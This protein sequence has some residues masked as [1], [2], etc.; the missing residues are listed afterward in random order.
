MKYYREQAASR[1]TAEFSETIEGDKRDRA[2]SNGSG[3]GTAPL[4]SRKEVLTV[5]PRKCERFIA[6]YI[7]KVFGIYLCA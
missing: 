6:Q 1:K 4:N 2:G 3:D 5:R 7:R